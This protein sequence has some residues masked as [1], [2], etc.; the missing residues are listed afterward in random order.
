MIHLLLGVIYLSFISL[1]LPDSLLGSA[2]PSMVVQYEVPVSFAGLVSM[3]IAFGTISSSLLS[4]RITKKFGA[5]LV[6]AVS[7]LTTAVA[8]FGFSTCKAFWMLCV[9]ALPYGLGAGSVDAALNNYV[10]LHYKSRQ[11]SWLHCMW[12]VG[13]ATG[14][15]IMGTVLTHGGNW[16]GG[17]RTISVVQMILTILIFISLPLWNKKK[18]ENQKELE[19]SAE[20][21][22][23][24]P[25]PLKTLV[26]FPGVPQVML[27]FFCY[28]A[29]EQTSGLWAA[30]YLTIFKGLAAE[31]AAG[32][33][34]LFYIGI[35][36]GRFINGFVTFRLEDRK[37]IRLGFGIISS[38]I[39]VLALP[40]NAYVSFAG[41]VLIG[42]GCAPIF[43][44]LIH[45]TPSNFG[46][47]KSQAIIGLQMASA[48]VG[49][50]VMPPLFGIMAN[51][52]AIWLL[53]VF[54][55]ICLLVMAFMFFE[56]CKK[57]DGLASGK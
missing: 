55:G 35:T 20:N 40:L 9:W 56:L 42:L 11:M 36:A 4:D 25:I 32:F 15:Y 57:T 6:T 12:G 47:D 7:V 22:D 8:L 26:R 28:C 51:F 49:I 43:P 2:W 37:L 21:K 41:F 44:C 14:P 27:C 52:I 33:A 39:I 48:Y 13:A 16:T 34:A 1:G 30:S 3:L 10:A 17:Y 46:E 38:G 53:P 19:V 23:L 24:E 31:T 45:S 50:C 54:L 18:S 5:G 29:L